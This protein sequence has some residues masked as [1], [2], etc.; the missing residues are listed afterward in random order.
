MVSGLYLIHDEKFVGGNKVTADGVTG[1]VVEV[2]IQRTR[3][4]D[5]DNEDLTTISN[6]N[7]T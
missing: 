1:S 2:G 3:I 6:K 5:Q 7:R 4:E